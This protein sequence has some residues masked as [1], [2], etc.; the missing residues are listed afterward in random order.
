MLSTRPRHSI[1]LKDFLPEGEDAKFL[2]AE[3]FVLVAKRRMYARSEARGAS[4]DWGLSPRRSLDAP[5]L[6]GNCMSAIE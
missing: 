5:Q 3:E 4:D 1:S 6:S 2:N